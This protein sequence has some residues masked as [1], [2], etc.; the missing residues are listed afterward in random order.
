VQTRRLDHL[1]TL[2]FLPFLCA[3]WFWPSIREGRIL[4]AE[5]LVMYFF[6]WRSALFDLAH[7]GSFSLWDPVPGLGMPRLSNV[8]AGYFSPSSLLFALVPTERAMS[9][10][11]LIVVCLLS[12]FTYGLFRIKGTDPLPSLFGA[13]SWAYA[14]M[15]LESVQHLPI[16]ETLLWLPGTL[17]CWEKFRV[18][19]DMK[20]AAG[21]SCC[22]FF[23]IVA[24]SP[25][26]LF[27]ALMVAGGWIFSGI[28]EERG[29]PL[30]FRRALVGALVLIV[31]AFLIASM[32][33]LPVLELMQ[34]SQRNLL[35]QGSFSDMYRAAPHEALLFLAKEIYLF[36]EPPPLV[37]GP[38]YRNIPGLSIVTLCFALITLLRRPRPLVLWAAALFFLFGTL[39]SA[40]WVTAFIQWAIPP[41]RMLRAPLRMVIPALFL[42]SWLS[43][44]GMHQWLDKRGAWRI[45]GSV[46]CIG[47]TL[48]LTWAVQHG[49][50]IFA[51]A[52]SLAIPPIFKSAPPRLAV[53]LSCPVATV[54]VGIREH[55][56]TVTIYDS[57]MPRTFFEA[58][59]ASQLGPLSETGILDKVI[60]RGTMIPVRRP[61]LPLM[62]A[63]NVRSAIGCEKGRYLITRIS[64]V[65]EKFFLATRLLIARNEEE[66]WMLAASG[67]WNPEDTA[68]VSSIPRGMPPQ[69][70]PGH[71]SRQEPSAVSLIAD[72]PDRQAVS[73]KSPRGG[74]LIESALLYP[75]WNVTIDHR[76]ALPVEA[77]LALRAVVVPP[78]THLVE[79]TYAPRWLVPSLALAATGLI[80]LALLVMLFPRFFRKDAMGEGMDEEM[81]VD[82]GG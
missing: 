43:A 77:D 1:I 10:Y 22:L 32:Q 81:A 65:P 48:S 69:D 60:S 41:L 8:Q 13:L 56:P 16:I 9:L 5:D 50:M 53:S 33:L 66:R 7:G 82:Q 79:W 3:L 64:A 42:I 29:D 24:G 46:L 34:N 36:I 21:A 17:F 62:R 4:W 57:L 74:L 58:L 45:A 37:H 71:A 76:P 15:V 12:L 80:L 78:G 27:Y 52:D 75:G 67:T 2:F 18:S 26:I 59:F 51:D 49:K 40:F 44:R 31:A 39:G 23:M 38:F 73:I 6:P 25:Q 72:L 47:W 63:F 61:D 14:G 54:N 30:N 11:P 68:L 28:M 19:K 70:P 20:W 55:V 35:S